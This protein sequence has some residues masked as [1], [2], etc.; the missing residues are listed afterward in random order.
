MADTL[1]NLSTPVA[2]AA[3]SLTF[4]DSA[5]YP[6]LILASIF[7]PMLIGLLLM[8]GGKLSDKFARVTGLAG[9]LLPALAALLVWLA[10][11]VKEATEAHTPFHFA[12]AWDLGL[13]DS[14]GIALRI[15]LNGIS[16]PLYLLAAIVGLAAGI[17]ACYGRAE[18]IRQ[19]LALLL[20]MH[21]GIMGVFATTDIFFFYLFHEIALIPTFVMIAQWGGVSR[22]TVAME[23]AVYLTIGAMLSLL[24][25]IMLYSGLGLESFDFAALLAA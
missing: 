1:D 3:T 22:R 23:M 8:V 2:D 7:G 14:L 12:H 4:Y 16:L 6:W 13:Q 10:Y 5:F 18:R 19:Y 15:G 9:F 17:Y 11:G 24:G 20:I 25:L 21:G